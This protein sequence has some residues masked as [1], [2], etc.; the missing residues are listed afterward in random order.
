MPSSSVSMDTPVQVVSSF[1]HFVTQWMSTV[2]VSWGSAMSSSQVQ[3]GGS[4][5]SPSMRK[6]QSAVSVRGVGPAES[7]GKS[8]TTYWP[9]GTRVGST[10]RRRRPRKPRETKAMA[11][12]NAA[13]SGSARHVVGIRQQ[14]Q[15]CLVERVVDRLALV[16]L[17]LGDE[18]RLEQV[19]GE[20]PGHADVRALPA[21]DLAARLAS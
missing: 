16:G 8:S 15:E 6:L 19:A 14:P 4:S 3:A 9:G 12:P 2:N 1:V 20:L 21:R 10:S 18:R 5:T 13:A 17:A 7:T 11:Q